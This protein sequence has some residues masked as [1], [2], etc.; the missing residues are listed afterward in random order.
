MKRN[1]SY[2]LSTLLFTYLFVSIANA[3]DVAPSDGAATPL[4]GNS[5]AASHFENTPVNYYSGIPSISIPLFSYDDQNGIGLGITLDYNAGGIRVNEGASTAGLGWN[6]NAGGVII[7]NVRG[8]PDD[9][10]G[11]GFMY[12]PYLPSNF[13]D[14]GSQLYHDSLDAQQDIFQFV[15][16]GA[17]GKFFIGKNKQI[18]TVPLSKLHIGYTTDTTNGIIVS[19]FII[20]EQ[21]VKYTFNE[22]EI[23]NVKHDNFSCGYNDVNYYSTWYLDNIISAFGKD[24][25]KFTYQGTNQ[26]GYLSFASSVNVSIDSGVTTGAHYS[27]PTAKYST[28][29][30]RIATISFPDKKLVSFIYDP[31]IH[32]DKNDFALNSI[33]IEDSVFRYGY[34]FEWDTSGRNFLTGIHSYT[35]KYIKPGYKFLYNGPYFPQLNSEADTLG[36]KRDHW[37]FYNAAA[38]DTN[39]I[40]TVSNLYTGANRNPSSS[41]IASSLSTIID[42]AG[43]K[44]FY[45]YEN[46]DIYRPYNLVPEYRRV[47]CKINGHVDITLSH[48]TAARDSFTI[49][50]STFASFRGLDVLPDGD[51]IWGIPDANMIWS[52]TNADSSV[53]YATDSINLTNLFFSKNSISFVVTGLPDGNLVFKTKLTTGTNS[54]FHTMFIDLSWLNQKVFAFN[55]LTVGGIRIKQIAH[56]DPVTGKTD[57]ISSYKYELANGRSS[58]FLGTVPVYNHPYFYTM[59][60]GSYDYSTHYMMISSEPVNNLDFTQGSP[61]GYSRVEIF[62]GSFTHNLGKEVYEYSTLQDAGLIFHTDA[63]PYAPYIQRDWAVGLQK[64]ISVYDNTGRLMQT[65]ENIYN[66]ITNNYNDSNFISLKLGLSGTTHYYGLSVID[67]SYLGEYY[68]PASGRSDLVS[69]TQTFYHTDNSVQVKMQQIEYDSNYN[70]VKMISSYDKSRGLLLERRMYYPYNYTIG[71]IVGKLRDSSIYTVIAT[72]DWITGDSNPRMVSAA[73][74]DFQQLSSGYIKPASVYSLQSNKPVSL[75]SIG[76]FDSAHLIRNS[77]WLKKQQEFVSYDSLG[78]FLEMKNTI[79]GQSNSL[80]MDYHGRLPVAKIS[81]AKFSDVAYTSFES[82][83]SGSWSIPSSYRNK[84]NSITGKKSY[85]LDSG[86]ITKTGLDA[87]A[88]Y[89]ISYWKASAATVS[90]SG[91]TGTAFIAEQ[92]G[93]KLYTQTISSTTSVTVSGSGLIDELRLYPKDANMVT[94]TF[95]PLIGVTSTCDANNKIS[96]CEYDSANRIVVLRDKDLNIIKKYEYSDTLKIRN[97]SGPIKEYVRITERN[98]GTGLNYNKCYYFWRYQDNIISDLFEDPTL[99]DCPKHPGTGDGVLI[100]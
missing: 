33:H 99:S 19:F 94:S 4:T 46:N 61:V 23:G 80:I 41:A 63:F 24:T 16:P 75:S 58:G 28:I 32:Y 57:T 53:I 82:D 73:I 25:I 54:P 69:S 29:S 95:E 98:P 70:A 34:M 22:Q 97:L 62:K 50:S 92:N 66:T 26:T 52:I 77:T 87:S 83:G 9:Y 40:P 1:I 64:K 8:M 71:G 38:N 36:N 11:S 45:T 51:S 7:R 14:K 85:S 93:W 15:I 31:A 55:K 49:A 39:K 79:S 13:K 37:G 30:K 43:G 3:Q 86:S 67:E 12:S 90:V 17:S 21:G 89:I 47:D 65:T 72:E 35:T 59:R 18:V 78:N 68:Y 88:T 100:N 5:M 44:T 91:A 20:N 84:T 2:L 42:P 81:N 76:A 27:I 74:T 10:P 56:F 48:V 6:I 60:H 96:Y